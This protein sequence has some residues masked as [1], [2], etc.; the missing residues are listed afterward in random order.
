M[1]YNIKGTGLAITDELRSYVE[2]QLAH[3]D[4]FV[5][6]DSTA[7]AD[8]ELQFDEVH[9]GGKYRA[10]FTGSCGGRVYRAAEWGTTLHEAIDVAGAQ[11]A[12]ELRGDKKKRLHMLRHMGARAKEYVRG[13]RNKV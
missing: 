3:A 8:V 9:D 5:A 2:R 1:N 11:F 6:G 10:E 12:R 13:W 7:H 4:K